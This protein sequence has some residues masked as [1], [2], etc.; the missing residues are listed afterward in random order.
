M[1]SKELDILEWK[2]L[3]CLVCAAENSTKIY[4]IEVRI[5]AGAYN[6]FKALLTGLTVDVNQT[7]TIANFDITTGNE[8]KKWD[9]QYISIMVFMSKTEYYL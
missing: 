3:F 5:E 4:Y 8:I 2:S 6:R 9:I 7:A 1:Y